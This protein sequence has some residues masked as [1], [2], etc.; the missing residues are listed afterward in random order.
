MARAIPLIGRVLSR[1]CPDEAE[2]RHLLS[3]LAA[4]NGHHPLAFILADLDCEIECPKC[5]TPIDLMNSNLN[6][7]AEPNAADNTTE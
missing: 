6:P 5:G 7:L 3:A 1:K 2:F 4:F